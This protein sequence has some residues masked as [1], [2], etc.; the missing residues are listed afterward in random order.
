MLKVVFDRLGVC[1]LDDYLPVAHADEHFIA[2]IH[3]GDCEFVL[4]EIDVDVEEL[5][6]VVF[7]TTLA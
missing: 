6:V 3:A 5:A 4:V 2:D 1:L 7:C